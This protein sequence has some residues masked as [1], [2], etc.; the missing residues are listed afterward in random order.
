MN[1]EINQ[2][3]SQFLDGEMDH[4]EM[5][6][7]LLIIK[8][9]PELKNKMNRYQTVRHVLRTDDA[10]IAYDCFLDKINQEIKQDP[11]YFIPKQQVKTRP[12]SVWQRASLAIAAT[13]VCVAVFLN[14]QGNVKN[15]ETNR[16]VAENQVADTQLQAT[17]EQQNK[18]HERFKAYLQKHSNELYTYGSL[19]VH[20][21]GSVASYQQD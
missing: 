1:I 11:H 12:Y 21:L 15:R 20:P 17:N 2:K 3:I 4:T 16:L 7:L 18:Q 6:K 19:D 8:Q 14:Q 10:P 13:V 5:E 9:Q